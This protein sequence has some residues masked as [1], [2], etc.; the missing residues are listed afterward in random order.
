MGAPHIHFDVLGRSPGRRHSPLHEGASRRLVTL[1]ARSDRSCGC[2]LYRL[3]TSKEIPCATRNCSDPCRPKDLDHRASVRK[4]TFSF[5]GIFR[6]PPAFTVRAMRDSVPIGGPFEEKT[7][8][9]YCDSPTPPT[10]YGIA[11]P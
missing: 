7:G 2:T 1:S 11:W 8:A 9:P 4:S 3:P 5:S 6:P 10:T